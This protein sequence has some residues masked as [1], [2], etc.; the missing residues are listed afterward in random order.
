MLT[1]Q[2]DGPEAWQLLRDHFNST[3]APSLMKLLEK[4]RTLGLEPTE[5]TVDYLTRAEYVSKLLE[6]AG[7][8]VCE[9][10]LT[11]IVLKDLPSEY[12]YFK[13][14]HNFSALKNF[15]PSRNLQTTTA[16][17]ETVALLL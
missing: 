4:F 14:V 8:K 5:S 10:M 7:L 9:N 15:E 11:L 16:S 6:L 17:N 2:G 13:T 3:E 1:N 12:D